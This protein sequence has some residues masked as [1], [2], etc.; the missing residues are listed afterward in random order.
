[1]RR[2]RASIQRQTSME[3]ARGGGAQGLAGNRRC[4]RACC[5]G[6]SPP[7]PI[8]AG[9]ASIAASMHVLVPKKPVPILRRA[10]IAH[11]GEDGRK[12]E[13]RLSLFAAADDRRAAGEWTPLTKAPGVGILCGLMPLLRCHHR[14]TQPK[15]RE[16]AGQAGGQAGVGG[17]RTRR[18][19]GGA[20]HSN[21]MKQ[22]VPPESTAWMCG[23]PTF[24]RIRSVFSS[25]GARESL[26][27]LRKK[28]GAVTCRRR[29]L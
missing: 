10:M 28:S 5:S 7:F 9:R 15:R 4:R 3:S 11:T 13:G 12:K 17:T 6:P 18:E 26:S 19:N 27:P 2:R 1:M 23:D 16:V 22:W 21:R 24:G 29:D 14:G 25:T 8:G 20:T